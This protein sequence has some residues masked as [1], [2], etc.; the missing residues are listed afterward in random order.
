[1][2]VRLSTRLQNDGEAVNRG[3][4]VQELPNGMVDYCRRRGNFSEV[5][6]RMCI[7][8]IE[9]AKKRVQRSARRLNLA[10]IFV[11]GGV[12]AYLLTA[13][14]LTAQGLSEKLRQEIMHS[15]SAKK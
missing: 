9:S 15:T 7:Q 5:A 1:M 13:T 12:M 4:F 3:L 6:K 11:L 8:G 10:L 2:V 14:L